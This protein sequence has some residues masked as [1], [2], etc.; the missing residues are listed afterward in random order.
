MILLINFVCPFSSF[1]TIA[2]DL[3]ITFPI[4][5]I[6]KLKKKDCLAKKVVLKSPAQPANTGQW[7]E[8]QIYNKKYFT[9]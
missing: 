6:N 4:R 7:N 3:W 2:S 5:D 8:W 1:S 9:L